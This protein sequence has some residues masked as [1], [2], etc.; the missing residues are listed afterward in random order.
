MEQEFILKLREALELDGQPVNL[1][2]N[3]RNYEEWNS[4][5]E[6]SLL[7]L[8]DAEYGIEIEMNELNRHKTVG[9]LLELIAIHS[10][11]Q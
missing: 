7:A 9:D 3:F 4:L 1:N 8:L 5:K 11:R 2:D 10:S 6:L